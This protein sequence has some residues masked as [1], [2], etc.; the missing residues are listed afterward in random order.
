VQLLARFDDPETERTYV[1]Q[2]RVARIPATRFLIILA[3][4]TLISYIVF[5]P[6]HFPREGVLDYNIAAGV[7]IVLLG[8]FYALTYTQFYVERGWVDIL[9]FTG[10]T[11]AMVLLIEALAKQADITGISRF[12]MAVINL[13]ILVVFASVGFVATTRYFL[14]WAGAL[15]AFYLAFLLQADRTI[16]N[17]VYTFTNFATFFTF[18][19]FVNWDIDRRARKTFAANLALEAEQAKTE[20]LLYN[21]LPQDVASRL[22]EGEAVADAFSDVSVIF[23]DIVGFSQLAKTMSPG[24][25]VKML[26][27]VFIRADECAERYGVE[28]VK[29]IGDAYL[30]VSGGNSSRTCRACDAIG[31]GLELIGAVEEI[32]RKSKIDL[33]VRIG[34]HTGPVVGGVIGNQRMVYDYWG[35]T[36]NVASRIEGIAEP[37]GIAVSEATFYGA[38][39]RIAF[40][41]PEL[42]TLKGVGEVKVY[43]VIGPL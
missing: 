41:E 29:T 3:V 5:N 42:V 23:V 6:M 33:K 1:A 15:L 2:E 17:K 37:N 27:T 30:A 16:V 4:G 13:G 10:L 28:K 32:A 39:E 14:L 20:Q 38:N 31:F 43:R 40:G 22:R 8:S 18:A 9:V 21:I 24:H 19:C 25:L 11:V 26:N 36:M 7:F 34:I 35:D 12:G